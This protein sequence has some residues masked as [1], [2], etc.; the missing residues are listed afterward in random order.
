MAT[1]RQIRA[2][3][4]NSRASCGART[5]E[6]R[7]ASAR[8]S[9]VHGMTATTLPHEDELPL[10]EKCRE[11]WLPELKA[12]GPVQMWVAERVIAATARIAWCDLQDEAWRYRK[13]E[14]AALN[15]VGDRQVE[16]AALGSRISNDP[17][18]VGLKLR[19][20]LDGSLWICRQLEVLAGLLARGAE[21]GDQEGEAR[22]SEDGLNEVNKARACDLLGL[23][24][25]QRQGPTVLDLPAGS[26][27]TI[28]AHQAAVIVAEI[29]ALEQHADAVLAELDE[30][31]QTAAR[32]D[33]GPGVDPTLRLYHRYRKDADRHRRAALA[34]LRQ[35]Q[36][37]AAA[38][39]LD[40][41]PFLRVKQPEPRRGAAGVGKAVGVFRG[42]PGTRGLQ[43]PI[44]P[45]ANALRP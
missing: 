33:R 41:C 13:A 4:R 25:E 24:Y 3:Q 30:T 36:S 10:I 42:A 28:V 22:A 32:L 40:F 1:L 26:T 29:A 44:P 35:M 23:S 6:G 15:W 14:R 45:I 31:D 20:T 7:R 27:L 12:E 11:D 5:L 19:Q 39:Q 17:E 18:V 34:E 37:D 8:N 2:N 21:A 16:T 9:T 43:K 38:A